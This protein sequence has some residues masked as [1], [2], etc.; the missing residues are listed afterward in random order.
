MFVAILLAVGCSL[1]SCKHR[2]TS[3]RVGKALVALGLAMFAL[4]S[5]GWA[6]AGLV[7]LPKSHNK[8][9]NAAVYAASCWDDRSGVLTAQWSIAQLLV[10]GG[11]L[12]VTTFCCRVEHFFLAPNAP[13][14]DLMELSPRLTALKTLEQGMVQ[15][16]TGP[17]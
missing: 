8:V 16:N 7:S 14:F 17:N 3:S 6:V 13:E 15:S 10:V 12:L 2:V 11:L 9:G 1:A 5:I 4:A